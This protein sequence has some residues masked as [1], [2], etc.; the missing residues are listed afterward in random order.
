MDEVQFGGQADIGLVEG[1]KEEGENLVDFDEED[2]GFLVEFWT[3]MQS[4]K[5]FEW[6]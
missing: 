1:D 5:L 4:V 2:P 3:K 6:W